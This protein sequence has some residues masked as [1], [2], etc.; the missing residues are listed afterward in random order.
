[1]VLV[2]RIALVAAL[3]YLAARLGISVGTL[4]GKVS[5]VWPPTGVAIAAV[6]LYGPS[7][8]PGVFIGEF[9]VMLHQGSDAWLVTTLPALGNVVEAYAGATL[10]RRLKFEPTLT[11]ARSIGALAAVSFVPTLISASV[12]TSAL[13][14]A[15]VTPG[16]EFLNTFR[17]WWFGNILGALVVIPVVMSWMTRPAEKP[18]GGRTELGFLVGAYVFCFA[19]ASM[20]SRPSVFLVY[21]L[22][23]W[24]GLRYGTRTAS[25]LTAATAVI[26]IARIA[27]GTGRFETGNT[28]EDVYLIDTFLG[29]LSLTG[30]LLA[31]VVAERNRVQR[32]LITANSELE[33]RVAERTDALRVDRFRL[34]QAQRVARIGSWEWDLRTDSISGSA[35]LDRL[36]G[37]ERS[38]GGLHY[39]AYSDKLPEDD[40]VALNDAMRAAVMHGG[41]FTCDVRMRLGDGSWRWLR[42]TGEP[43][44]EPG[45]VTQMHGSAQDI[46]E[47]KAAEERI[48]ANEERSAAIVEAS[49]EAFVSMDLDEGITDWNK[50]AEMTFGWTRD[51]AMGRSLV[52]LIIPPSLREAHRRGVDRFLKTGRP[53]VLNTRREVTA[54]HRD[55]HEFPVEMAVWMTLGPDG[56]PAFHAYLHDISERQ[57]DKAKLAFALEEARE[58]SRMKSAFLANMSHEIRTPM[59][60]VLGMVGFLLDTSLDDIQRDYV[61]TMAA[62]AEALM[63]IID[64][65]LDVSKIEAGKLE[66]EESDFDLR[67]LLQDT[68]RPFM[69]AA[70][71]KG[72]ALG[73][74]VS[75]SIP[76][77]IRGDRL[78]LRQVVSNLVSNAVKFT[79]IGSVN[80]CVRVWDDKLLFEVTD[81]GIG[82]PED[83]RAQL[84]EPFTQADAST[85]R[86]YGGT[87]LGLAICRQLVTLMGGDIGVTAAQGGGSRFW[88]S[89]PMVA[90]TVAPAPIVTEREQQNLRTSGTGRKVMVVEDNPVNRKVAV[91]MLEHLGYT[92]EIAV[93]GVE[94]ASLFQPGVF[95]AI[96][97]DCQMPRMDGYDA[98][99][100]IRAQETVSHTPIIAMTASAMASDR[101]RCIA[102]G[103]DDFLSKPIGTEKLGAT[104][105]N[106][107]GEP[108]SSAAPPQP[109]GPEEA[110]DLEVAEHLRSLDEDGSFLLDLLQMFR[111]DSHA[112]LQQLQDAIAAGDTKTI[113]GV[114]HQLKGSTGLLGLKALSA[115]CADVEHAHE[116]VSTAMALMDPVLAEYDRAI[117]YVNDLAARTAA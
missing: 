93:D 64:D 20:G 18:E 98:T 112:L 4:P 32:E 13:W 51:E 87:G 65:V 99:R 108:T 103:M 88:F 7:V 78:R 5:P 92:V 69:P 12:G 66:I 8:L 110:F 57:A 14:L 101:D 75:N 73:A 81:S 31:S 89:I 40:R 72:I 60:G 77:A 116:S 84:F 19:L 11:R 86:R 22:I 97:M 80:V 76:D 2:G 115:A 44:G 1:M 61:Q 6:Y 23:A 52:E 48:R 54:M 38:P 70:N 39:S 95:D 30:L 113:R 43:D 96:L 68:L 100:A 3:Y 26:A 111:N 10:L 46:T 16:P 105:N 9:L 67:R 17:A 59:N 104:L 21:P 35:E 106:W 41:S 45:D 53:Q 24:A 56:K 102:A 107:I 47:V 58:A 34:E 82:I 15:S 114:A 63:A 117:A 91:G 49:A 42:I 83:R 50:Q 109:A 28:L 29:V 74:T 85:T 33:A 90:A 71:D 27:T 62:S 25:T 55:G 79:A 94:A 36:F 37:V